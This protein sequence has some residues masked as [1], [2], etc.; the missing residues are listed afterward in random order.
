[1]EDPGG[2]WEPL[3]TSVADDCIGQQSCTVTAADGSLNEVKTPKTAGTAQAKFKALVMCRPQDAGG[4]GTGVMDESSPSPPPE[5]TKPPQTTPPE[6]TQPPS[7]P[8]TLEPSSP[9]SDSTP[10]STPGTFVQPIMP[11]QDMTEAPEPTMAPEGVDMQPDNPGESSTPKPTMAPPPPPPT[12]PTDSN[13]PLPEVPPFPCR[14]ACG[15]VYP[16]SCL[17]P[18]DLL[19]SLSHRTPFSWLSS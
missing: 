1:M 6:V 7:Q 14:G 12:V 18:S 8:K 19:F 4:S 3:P 2:V 10:R 16:P 17:T 11:G 9:P 5:T 13:Q 15:L